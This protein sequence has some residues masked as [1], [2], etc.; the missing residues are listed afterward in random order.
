[1]W[2]CGFVCEAWLSC[3]TLFGFLG[4]CFSEIWLNVIVVVVTFADADCQCALLDARI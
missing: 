4:S 3:R 2:A 1:M